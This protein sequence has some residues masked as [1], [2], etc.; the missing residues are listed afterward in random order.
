MLSASLF[1]IYLFYYLYYYCFLVSV[2]E[3]NYYANP[4][5]NMLIKP[6]K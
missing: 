2:N 6:S 5:V 1:I 4:F 3:K